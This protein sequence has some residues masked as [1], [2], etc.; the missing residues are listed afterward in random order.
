MA[1]KENDL[2]GVCWSNDAGTR[3]IAVMWLRERPCAID[4]EW[5]AGRWVHTMYTLPLVS[6]PVVIAGFVET[7]DA[8]LIDGFMAFGRL[9]EKRLRTRH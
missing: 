3:H 4:V 6:D 7:L 9:L 1:P 5:V 8:P 2:G